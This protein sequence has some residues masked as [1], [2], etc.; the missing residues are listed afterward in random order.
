[1]KIPTIKRSNRTTRL[2]FAMM[3]NKRY[4]VALVCLVAGLMAAQQQAEA[5]L[6]PMAYLRRLDIMYPGRIQE[7][8]NQ[9]N[10][11]MN[12]GMMPNGQNGFGQPGYGQNGYNQMPNQNGYQNPNQNGNQ[13]PNQNGNQFPNQNGNQFPNQ[14]GNQIP[15]QNGNQIPNQNGSQGTNGLVPNTGR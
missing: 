1:M 4:F 6:D 7:Y 9:R 3:N 12:N 14:N 8:M 5:C 2:E 11:G 15:N 10:N 13:F